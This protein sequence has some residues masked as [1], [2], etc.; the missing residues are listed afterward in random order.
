MESETKMVR[1][2]DMEAWLH[3]VAHGMTDRAGHEDLVQEGRIAIWDALDRVD[4]GDPRWPGY[5]TLV[6]R[7][8]MLDVV[9][10]RSRPLGA[11]KPEEVT[12]T[13]S[14]GREARERI[15][16]YLAHHP[17]ATGSQIAAG[18]GLSPSTV[19]VQRRQLDIDFDPGL[20]GSLDALVDAGYNPPVQTDLLE[21]VIAAYARGEIMAALDV[22]TPNERRYVV[23]R[24]WEGYT[25]AE[26]ETEFGYNPAAVWRTAKERLRPIL[27][28]AS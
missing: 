27:Q 17:G 8:R 15:R 9:S 18:T 2:S 23:L 24:F 22:L 7:G 1:L 20:P 6:A 3:R 26:L 19:S 5:V 4:E 28:E 25:S 11:P 21:H 13:T 10:G 14:R 12:R 16:T